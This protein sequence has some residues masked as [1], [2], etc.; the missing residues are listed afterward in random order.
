MRLLGIDYGRKR[1]GIALS[2]MEQNFVFPKEI[3]ENNENLVKK[4][5]E[6]INQNEIGGVV[7]GESVDYDG[8]DNPLMKAI[9]RFADKLKEKINIPIYFEEEI[10]TTQ[11]AKRLQDRHA[12][13]DASA[14]AIILQTFIDRNKNHG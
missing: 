8:K 13:I 4:I 1:V 3:I 6:I 10:L 7:I 9:N 14:A 12:K 2:D 5:V 11:E